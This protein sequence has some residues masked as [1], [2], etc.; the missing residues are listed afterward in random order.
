MLNSAKSAYPSHSEML[1]NLLSEAYK[2]AKQGLC[3][4]RIL[5]DQNTVDSRL[6]ICSTCEK[7]SAEDK[8]C[9]VCGCFM[10]VKANIESSDCPDGK[11]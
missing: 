1:K 11:W 8:R 6:E 7:F 2:T 10:L 4:E 9:T 5:A 3:G